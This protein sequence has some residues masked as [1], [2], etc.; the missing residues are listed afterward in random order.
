MKTTI[1]IIL[2]LAISLLSS[3]GGVSTVASQR[4]EMPKMPEDA[5]FIGSSP[6]PCEVINISL[7]TY[8]VRDENNFVYQ[9]TEG[10]LPGPTGSREPYHFTT[11]IIWDLDDPESDFEIYINFN[12]HVERYTNFETLYG[13]HPK[14]LC[15][16][17]ERGKTKL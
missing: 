7:F 5:I 16:I 13:A 14:G 2:A 9:V 4:L 10:Y 11:F 6:A 15:D 12:S 1:S 8:N 17:V 3:F